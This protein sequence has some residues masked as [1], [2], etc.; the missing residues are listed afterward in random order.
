MRVVVLVRAVVVDA[1]G[2]LGDG[3]VARVAAEPDVAAAGGD[4]P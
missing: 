2:E 1:R 3:A 4:G